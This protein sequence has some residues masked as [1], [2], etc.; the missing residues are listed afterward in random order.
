MKS[1]RRPVA[2]GS[3]GNEERLGAGHPD[4]IFVASARLMRPS[5]REAA[6]ATVS[7]ARGGE[8]GCG[9]ACGMSCSGLGIC[10][11]RRTEGGRLER[12]VGAHPGG[13]SLG[14]A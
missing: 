12:W 6:H 9:G 3:D 8:S 2:V 11:Q 14:A 4:S 10:R 1:A 13:E 7:G 5:S